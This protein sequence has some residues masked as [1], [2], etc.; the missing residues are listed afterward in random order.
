MLCS[1]HEKLISVVEGCLSLTPETGPSLEVLFTYNLQDR[2]RLLNN[3]GWINKI[4]FSLFPP[5]GPPVG[6]FELPYII[7]WGFLLNDF[8]KKYVNQ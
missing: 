3:F 5:A 4:I 6:L 2:K 1:F 8:F 7:R